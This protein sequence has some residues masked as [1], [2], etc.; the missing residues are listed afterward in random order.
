MATNRVKMRLSGTEQ[1][2]QAWINYLKALES[3]EHIKIYEGGKLYQNRGSDDIY[4]CYM[5]VDLLL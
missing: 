5:E 1:E 3:K 4:R 2:L